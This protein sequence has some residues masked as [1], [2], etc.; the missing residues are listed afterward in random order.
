MD[1]R[2]DRYTYILSRHPLSARSGGR[3]QSTHRSQSASPIA[4]RLDG[5]H[6]ASSLGCTA[7]GAAEKSPVNLMEGATAAHSQRRRVRLQHWLFNSEER[8]LQCGFVETLGAG[9]PFSAAKAYT[10]R[11]SSLRRV[12]ERSALG[13]LTCHR[14]RGGTEPGQ[15][16]VSWPMAANV[17][18]Y[19]SLL[20]AV[21]LAMELERTA[22]QA[23][24]WQGG[25]CVSRIGV[26]IRRYV[27]PP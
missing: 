2:V 1:D 24:A 14:H 19:P 10:A 26:L 9:W 25:R 6:R 21:L 22:S 17:S 16:R 3:F 18:S 20:A 7:S 15:P 11:G 12:T 8:L 27:R 5:S 4:T 23:S 13:D